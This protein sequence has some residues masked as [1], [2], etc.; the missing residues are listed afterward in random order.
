MEFVQ[1]VP[2]DV[3]DSIVSRT[4]RGISTGS[5]SDCGGQY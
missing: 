5:I 4:V 2:V 3:V 1:V